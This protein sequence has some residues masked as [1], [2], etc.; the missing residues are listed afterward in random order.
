MSGSPKNQNLVISGAV[1]E[2][3]IAEI[4]LITN[5]AGD[6]FQKHK[7]TTRKNRKWL[8]K[9]LKQAPKLFCGQ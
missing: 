7:K 4:S 5:E 3:S 8:F 6:L 1:E 9:H 2:K